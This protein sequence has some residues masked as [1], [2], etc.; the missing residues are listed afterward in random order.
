MHLKW[1]FKYLYLIKCARLLN[2][3]CA[4]M[5]LH[6]EPCLMSFV[7]ICDSIIQCF[8]DICES[9]LFIHVFPLNLEDKFDEFG[10]ESK[11]SLCSLKVFLNV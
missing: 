1:K 2:L 10:L 3:S 6:S 7:D 4:V 9:K 8:V 11:E 5:V